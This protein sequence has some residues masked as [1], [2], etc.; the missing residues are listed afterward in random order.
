MTILTPIENYSLL[1][2]LNRISVH[3]QIIPDTKAVVRFR[4]FQIQ[5]TGESNI[6]D[7][8]IYLD[9]LGAG[10]ITDISSLLEPYIY[11][12]L[13]GKFRFEFTIGQTVDNVESVVVY[14]KCKV[15]IQAE[16]FLRNYYLSLQQSTLHLLPQ[17]L[18]Y[19]HFFA[20]EECEVKAVLKYDN[21]TETKTLESIGLDQLGK[22]ATINVA[23]AKFEKPGAKLLSYEI[24]AGERSVE[25]LLDW[26]TPDRGLSFAF[27]NSFGVQEIFYAKGEHTLDVNL[28]RSSGVFQGISENFD[29][30]ETHKHK[31]F[32]GFMNKSLSYYALDFI[33]SKEIYLIRTGQLNKPILVTDSKVIASSSDADLRNYEVEFQPAEVNHNV[34]EIAEAGRIFDHTFDNTF[35]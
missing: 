20:I 27:T 25:Y 13:V 9:K 7:G 17:Q 11:Q 29:I 28:D 32:T 15:D 21:G 24:V 2:N 19:V 6:F 5:K 12:T 18:Q 22:L 30:K 10:A 14:S 34:L 26:I 8:N 33:R 1:G 35:N 16:Y 31:L 23:P 4:I 3:H